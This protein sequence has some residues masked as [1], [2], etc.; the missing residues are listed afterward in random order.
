MRMRTLRAAWPAALVAMLFAAGTAPAWAEL[1]GAPMQTPAGATIQKSAARAH[2]AAAASSTSSISAAASYTVR[3]TTLSTGTLVREYI[4]Q[5]GSVFGVAWQGPRMPDVAA[6]LGSYFPQ[7]AS[8]VEAA[9]AARGGG[10]GPAN[11]RQPNLVVHSAGHPG[12]F[13]GQAYLPQSLPSGVTGSD[14]Q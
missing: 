3:Q 1:G 4:G 11:V 13:A 14:I 8:A 6:L 7:A 10:R 2:A 9:R 5:N 12:L